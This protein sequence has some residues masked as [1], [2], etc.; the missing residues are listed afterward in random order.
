ME[1]IMSTSTTIDIDSTRELRTELIRGALEMLDSGLITGTAGNLSVRAGDHIIIT[2]S[3]AAYDRLEPEDLATVDMAGRIVDVRGENRP[4]S[5]TPLHLA[6]YRGTDARAVVHTHSPFANAVGLVRDELPRVHY[7]IRALGGRVRVAPYATFGTQELADNVI[8][9]ID[10]RTGCILRNHGTVVYGS[11]MAEALDRAA[12]L[13]WVS[14]LY[15]RAA[16]LG[17]PAELTDDD[18]ELVKTQATNLGYR[19]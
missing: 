5:E 4:S 10:G 17:E 1:G 15:W 9:A 2:P 13:E 12:K 7:A 16:Q 6:V 11:S 14:A 3:G 19:S 18:L 8:A